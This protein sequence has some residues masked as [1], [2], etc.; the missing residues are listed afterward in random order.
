MMYQLWKHLLDYIES[1][2]EGAWNLQQSK[3]TCYK[4][5]EL[6]DTL[7]VTWVMF[8]C[9]TTQAIEEQIIEIKQQI[10]H[11]NEDWDQATVYQDKLKEIANLK[12]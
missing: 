4:A 6:V 9:R 1:T 5:K 7:V 11:V 12:G 3:D 8:C 10:L 2:T